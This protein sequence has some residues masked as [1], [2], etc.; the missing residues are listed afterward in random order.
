MTSTTNAPNTLIKE[1]VQVYIAKR[2]ALGDPKNKIAKHLGISHA[3][4]LSMER[5]EWQKVSN[6]LLNTIAGQL[7]LHDWS[8]VNT[9]NFAKIKLLCEDAHLNKRFLAI[10]GYTGGGKTTALR[11]YAENNKDVAY[12]HANVLMNR[13][14]LLAAI[15]NALDLDKEGTA[16]AMM[17]SIIQKL[18][19]LNNPCV[20]IDDAGKLHDNCL[21]LL[22]LIY[23]ETENQCGIV[24]AG[25]E[26]M[27]NNIDKFATRDKLGFKELKRRI[28]YWLPLSRP[29]EN[30]IKHI[31][32]HYSITDTKAIS[33]LH[34]NATDYG[35]LRNYI[36]N[37]LKAANGQPITV[38]VLAAL[39]LGDRDYRNE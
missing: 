21:R 10:A 19:S 26:K 15:L 25:T 7:R 6:D 13:K 24:I 11:H 38:E 14:D 31:A 28:A 34:K 16:A 5:G 1:K 3:H 4:L 17:Q 8:I 22:Q 35:T 32:A 36:T 27:K 12:I 9:P 30:T 37:A 18:L 20:I 23:D 2:I 33:F 39:Q 29:R